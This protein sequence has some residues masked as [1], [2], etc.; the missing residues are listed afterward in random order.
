MKIIS[1][2]LLHDLRVKESEDIVEQLEEGSGQEVEPKGS[3][4]RLHYP[5]LWFCELF[6][7]FR[8]LSTRLRF[9]AAVIIETIFITGFPVRLGRGLSV[10]QFLVL[11]LSQ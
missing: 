3:V 5:D 6:V 1:I 9:C 11:F 8:G 2:E 7:R 4:H 10:K